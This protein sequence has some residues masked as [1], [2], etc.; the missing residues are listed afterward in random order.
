[1]GDIQLEDLPIL[2][3]G[4]VV[5]EAG[6]PVP[7]LFVQVRYG[8][9]KR[10]RMEWYNHNERPYSDAEG[11]FELRTHLPY[12]RIKIY[13]WKIRKGSSDE[14]QVPVGTRD[15]RLV[16]V[17]DEP[18]NTRGKLR[19]EILADDSI[20]WGGLEVRIRRVDSKKGSRDAMPFAG[21]YGIDRLQPGTYRLEVVADGHGFDGPDFV[22]ETVED[23]EVRAGEETI[24]PTIDLRGRLRLYE[25]TVLD[26]AG[27]RIHRVSCTV[28]NPHERHRGGWVY[29]GRLAFITPA[30]L[31]SV[32]VGV[33]EFAPVV[34]TWT[35]EPQTITVR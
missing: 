10:G 22:F 19:G 6:A 13:A 3:A 29:D 25:L 1:M 28:Q 24:V 5:D 33:G 2:V 9:M 7:S 11:R 31:L 34:V 4:Q 23:I 8:L 32:E 26:A 20:P 16:Y 17:P 14:Q 18:E 27:E 35:E 12:E 21:A 30:D 15:V